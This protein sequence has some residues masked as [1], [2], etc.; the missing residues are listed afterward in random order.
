MTT[1]KPFQSKLTPHFEEIKQLRIQRKTWKEIA[2]H[3]QQTYRIHTAASSCLEFFKRH[4]K[5]PAPLGFLGEKVHSPI[6]RARAPKQ[7]RPSFPYFEDEKLRKSIVSENK[8]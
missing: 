8:Y 5:R 6:E 7:Q 3:L 1:T 2:V 4:R